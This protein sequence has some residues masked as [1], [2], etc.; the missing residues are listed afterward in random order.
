MEDEKYIL[1]KS[2]MIYIPENV[3]HC[4]LRVVRVDRPFMFLAVS[5]ASKYSKDKIIEKYAG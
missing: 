3:R 4:P 1:E 2:C 5:M